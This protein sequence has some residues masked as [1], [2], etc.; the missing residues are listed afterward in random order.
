MKNL[1]LALFVFSIVVLVVSIIFVTQLSLYAAAG[2]LHLAMFSFAMFF[3]WKKNISETLKSL[4]V[5][6]DLRKNLKYTLIGLFGIFATLLIVGIA[7]SLLGINDQEKILDKVLDLPLIILVFAFLLAPIT[8]EL[9]FR[10]MMVQ[11]ILERSNPIIAIILSSVVFSLVH[12]SYE[13]LVEI[14]GVFFIGLILGSIYVKAKSLTP[15]ILIHMIYNLLAI[16]VMR[17]LL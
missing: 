4:G 14:L 15:C 2:S 10:G 7:A 17:F 8:E 3:I 5:P 13:S 11:K 12:F 9:F 6:G 1:F 16:I